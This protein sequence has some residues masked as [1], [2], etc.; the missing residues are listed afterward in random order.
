MYFLGAWCCTSQD[1][2]GSITLS[3]AGR[4]FSRSFYS[5][6]VCRLWW[7]ID[8]QVSIWQVLTMSWLNKET[9]G[10]SMRKLSVQSGPAR[11]WAVSYVGSKEAQVKKAGPSMPGWLQTPF[12]LS[13]VQGKG[14]T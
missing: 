4:G 6:E 10:G 12:L 8:G 9:K 1:L 3:D 2:S 5:L 11:R 14:Y 13:S 7:G